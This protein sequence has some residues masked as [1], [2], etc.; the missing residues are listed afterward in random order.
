MNAWNPIMNELIKPP[1]DYPSWLSDPLQRIR[2]AQQ[3]A[4]LFFSHELDWNNGVKVVT[5]GAND[6]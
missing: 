2:S 1:S 5:E 6:E 4:T 3:H